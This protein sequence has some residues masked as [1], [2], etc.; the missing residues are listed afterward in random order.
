MEEW[1]ADA[2]EPTE[3]SLRR[4]EECD[5]CVLLVAWNRGFVPEG[6]NDSITQ[7][8]YRW[9][10]RHSIP[11]LVFLL[12]PDAPW[13][14]RFDHTH[15]DAGVLS[16]RAEL[17]K[18]VGREFFGTAPDSVQVLAAV[19]R[20]EAEDHAADA[21]SAVLQPLVPETGVDADVFVGRASVFDRI[22]QWIRS[23]TGSAG[24]VMLGPPGIGKSALSAQ[25]PGRFEEV[26]ALHTCRH[27][28]A[29]STNP[30]RCATSVAHKLSVC[31]DEYRA[32]LRRLPLQA[33]IEQSSPEALGDRLLVQPLWS[34]APPSQTPIIV[35]VDALDEA[36]QHGR[37]EL[38]DFLA[39]LAAK[40]PPWCRFLVTARPEPEVL[41]ALVS[42]DSI[43]LD[44]ASPENL[45]DL[46]TFVGHGLRRLGSSNDGPAAQ[47]LI[48][49][50]DG[51]F[52]YVHFVLTELKAGRLA[53]ERPLEFP[54][55]LS[56]VYRAYF[57]RR[58]ENLDAYKQR[59]RPALQ[60][61]CAAQEAVPTTLLSAC[62]GWDEQATTDFH[63]AVGALF[64]ERDGYIQPFHRSVTEWLTD[65]DLAAA[66]FVSEKSGDSALAAFG[67]SAFERGEMSR[68][69][70]RHLATHLANTGQ[71]ARLERL[72][73]DP[74]LMDKTWG[75]GTVH[76]WMHFWRLVDEGRQVGTKYEA[77]LDALQQRGTERATLATLADRV[78]WLLGEMG[79]YADARRVA[80]QGLAWRK[81]AP[82]GHDLDVSESLFRL[83]ELSRLERDFAAARPLYEESLAIRQRT[84]GKE[85]LAATTLHGLGELFHDQKQY[86]EAQR[87]YEQSL[88]ILETA[89]SADDVALGTCVNDLGA[90]HF[91][92][93][94]ADLAQ[95]LYLRAEHIFRAALGPRHPETASAEF[96]RARVLAAT[97]PGKAWPLFL[98]ALEAHER[99]YPLAHH[100]VAVCREAYLDVLQRLDPATRNIA[101][102][103]LVSARQRA[104]GKEHEFV[105]STM[106]MV[107]WQLIRDQP[108]RAVDWA[109]RAASGYAAQVGPEHLRTGNAL[110]TL[111]RC[112]QV[113]GRFAEALDPAR[114]AV[115]IR[116]KHKDVP[117]KDLG[118]SLNNLGLVL[119]E[120]GKLDEAERVLNQCLMTDADAPNANY[121][122][123]RVWQQRSASDTSS[124]QCRT[125]EL[126]HWQAFLAGSSTDA[127]KREHAIE[128]LRQLGADPAPPPAA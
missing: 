113:A 38:A 46:R 39:S 94:R 128:R 107:A 67:W 97:D 24:L 92:M 56:G 108:S 59:V 35:V 42:F 70:T 98:R 52:L 8:E 16:W 123:G 12:D 37:N 105:W 51:S 101:I 48:D 2:D 93:G 110:N 78:A 34:M 82:D 4:V 87:A 114:L 100:K 88:S 10:R 17:E 62:L 126:H 89:Q 99:V 102:E 9:A 41:S 91:E 72:L 11:V 73:T 103:A 31:L 85:L 5:L 50:S 26:K 124:E 6:S 55:G 64:P 96:N 75:A 109:R 47:M 19:R 33:L 118:V 79:L 86:G 119:V 111:V 14:R 77:M 30:K 120:L 18:S 40:T 21:L 28:N 69:M 25:L 7:M 58:F 65:R 71:V 95:P 68:Y 53:L 80:G 125:R 121:W 74:G 1:P 112:L 22:R 45:D 127:N 32:H 83:A 84:P 122:L 3:F 115:E 27:G 60:I 104:F 116:R 76:E 13:K 61:V 90:L 36:T 63:Q 15:V 29:P 43:G 117:P 49:R 81:A 54:V 20:L 57:G 44:A 23:D 66:Y 106:E